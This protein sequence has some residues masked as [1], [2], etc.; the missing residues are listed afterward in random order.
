MLMK[1]GSFYYTTQ[2]FKE[3]DVDFWPFIAFEKSPHSKI[4]NKTDTELH[5]ILTH[6]GTLKRYNNNC[7]EMWCANICDCEYE[8]ANK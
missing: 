6:I 5:R 1:V 3:S 7:P 2:I 4:L 8:P